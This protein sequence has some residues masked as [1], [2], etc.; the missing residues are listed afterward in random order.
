MRT[1][2]AMLLFAGCTVGVGDPPST[3][4]SGS[5]VEQGSGSSEGSG[6]GGAPVTPPSQSDPCQ[7]DPQGFDCYCEQNPGDPQCAQGS[8]A[9]SDDPCT[10]DPT[11]DACYCE[12]NPDDPYCSGQ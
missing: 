2:L 12:Q 7:V 4:G 1:L 11:G 9:G 10:T 3:A 6:G 8:G 5:P